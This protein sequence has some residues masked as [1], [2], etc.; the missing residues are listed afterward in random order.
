MATGEIFKSDRGSPNIWSWII[1][2]VCVA[3]IIGALLMCLH[4]EPNS[5]TRLLHDCVD[6]TCA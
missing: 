1:P 2:I 5:A 3:S 4:V 6:A